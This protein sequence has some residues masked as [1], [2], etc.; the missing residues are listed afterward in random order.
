M[1]AAA[2]PLDRVAAGIV[3]ETLVLVVPLERAE[4]CARAVARALPAVL[5]RLGAPALPPPAPP[6][7][8]VATQTNRSVDVA[9]AASQTP[10]PVQLQPVLPP[11]AKPL[12]VEGVGL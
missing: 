6:A 2:D 4:A 9:A 10:C 11:V 7:A 12:V 5:E 1:A 3:G 8:A